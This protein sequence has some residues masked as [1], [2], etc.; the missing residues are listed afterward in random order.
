MTKTLAKKRKKRRALAPANYFKN[1]LESITG[2]KLPMRVPPF[3]A[4]RMSDENQ[5]KL[6]EWCVSNANPIW[7]T[8][9]SMIEAAELIVQSAIENGNIEGPTRN[10]RFS[11]GGILGGTRGGTFTNKRKRK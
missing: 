2:K 3:K 8:G 6:Q 9:L 10:A 5:L 11:E 4:S 7:A 1:A